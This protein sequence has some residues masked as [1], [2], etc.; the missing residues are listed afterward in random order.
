MKPFDYCTVKKY[1]LLYQSNHI[2]WYQF[3]PSNLSHLSITSI[4]SII[5]YLLYRLGLLRII[6]EI[7]TMR[8]TYVCNIRSMTY[9][10]DDHIHV[11]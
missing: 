2:D 9:I 4:T 8:E 6:S 3:N 11:M 5:A 10:N 7:F 1:I